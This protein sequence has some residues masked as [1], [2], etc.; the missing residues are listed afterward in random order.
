MPMGLAHYT[1]HW[2]CQKVPQE[3]PLEEAQ[4]LADNGTGR[5]EMSLM[6]TYMYRL[7]AHAGRLL[8][9][10]CLSHSGSSR[11]PHMFL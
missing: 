2:H 9:T 7:C 6:N 1:H 11:G 4:I 10:Q 8:T 3:I 5:V